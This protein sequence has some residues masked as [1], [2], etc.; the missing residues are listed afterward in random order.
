MKNF[1]EIPAPLLWA[2][3]GIF[4]L[5]LLASAT[6]I[7]LTRLRPERDFT[8]LRQRVRSWW[9]MV[10]VFAV[11]IGLDRRLS[12]FFLGFVSFLAL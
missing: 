6:T 11:A 12:F 7:T 3:A 2:M 9:A 10:A 8:E 1:P 5:L 4:V